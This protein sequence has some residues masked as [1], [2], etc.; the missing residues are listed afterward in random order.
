[1]P[2]IF[3]I[4]NNFQRRE[5][6]YRDILTRDILE[7][8]SLRLTGQNQYSVEFDDT[9]YNKGRLIKIE[10]EGKIN[11][12]SISEN[13]IRSR[14]SFFQSFPSALV[15]YYQETNLNKDL[16]FYFLEPNGN[17]ETA[18]F[19]FMYRL[20]K[21]VGTIF[22]NEQLYLSQEYQPF[23]TITDIV[24]SK[25]LIR[26]RNTGNASTYLAL[27]DNNM[28]QIFGKTYGAN[29][30]ET[31]LLALAIKNISANPI[32]LYEIQDGNL[33]ILPQ[34]GRDI[35]IESGINV[36][37]SDLILERREFENNDSLRSPT[38]LYNLLDKLGEKKCA[39]C[40]C[41]IAQI[42]Q[43]AHIWSVAS[44]KRS[45]N[46]NQD[47][48][49]RHALHKDNGIWLCSNHHKLFDLDVIAI[50]EDGRI[51]YKNNL[52]RIQ[53]SYLRTITINNEINN[54]FI[55]ESFLNYLYRRNNMI[56]LTS[57]SFI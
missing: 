28:L 9:G 55:N 31:I 16:Y 27:D 54:H 42:I 13:E 5:F 56:D 51:K 22:L 57:Y 20:M 45:N 52:N 4:K 30:Y 46:I 32:E 35:I 6:S 10:F 48:K 2:A 39:L 34:P 36:I 47:E 44:I 26:Q 17:I 43:G 29:K 37:T 8:L 1:M 18:Y 50:N 33:S 40:E 21:T 12:V 3:R 38:Y 23:N 11:Y 25:D 24:N 53:E 19:I 7:D 14:N 15:Q 41:Q 49:L